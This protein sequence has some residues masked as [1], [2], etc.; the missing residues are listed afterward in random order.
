MLFTYYENVYCHFFFVDFILNY[1]IIHDVNTWHT[2]NI[3]APVPHCGVNKGY[4]YLLVA[5][6]FQDLITCCD[7]AQY[8]LKFLCLQGTEFMDNLAHCLR[9]YVADRLS[10]D[11]GWRN[12]TVRLMFLRSQQCYKQLLI[13]SD[14]L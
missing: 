14:I 5:E 1:L 9:Y 4:I 13:V 6:E 11:P 12:L 8:K 2:C 10:N 7:L 3:G